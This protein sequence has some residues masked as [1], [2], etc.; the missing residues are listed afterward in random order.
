MAIY[1]VPSH[2]SDL[3]NDE[4]SLVV[5]VVDVIV[6]AATAATQVTIHMA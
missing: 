2:W 1:K 4:V 6:A 5:F 3:D